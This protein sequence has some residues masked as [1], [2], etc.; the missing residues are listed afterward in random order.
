MNRKTSTLLSMAISIVLIALGVGFLYNHNMNFWPANGR[1]AMGHHGMM[2]GGMGIIM[3]L[4]WILIIGVLVLLISALV[5]SVSGSRQDRN[6]ASKPLDILKQRYARGEID[7]TEYE[8][9]KREL[10]M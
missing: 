7:K 10:S 2:G 3:V 1:W 5:N 8:E 4:F 9:M 6:E